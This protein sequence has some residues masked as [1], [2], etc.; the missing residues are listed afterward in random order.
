MSDMKVM[1]EESRNVKRIGHSDVNGWGDAFQVIVRDE[2][3]CYLSASGMEGHEGT[4]ILDVEDPANPKVV[5]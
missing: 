4:S 3:W 1:P 5:K 2:K